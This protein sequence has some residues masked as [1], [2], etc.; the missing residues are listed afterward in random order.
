MKSDAAG[1]MDPA[2]HGKM[3]PDASFV[4]KAAMGG[5]MEVKLGEAATTR[6]SEEAVK[7]YGRRMVD[8]HGKANGELKDLATKK[9]WSLPA[10]LDE[11]HKKMSEKMTMLSGAEFDRAYSEHMLKDHEMVVKEFE[12]AAQKAAD[13]DLRAWATKTLP[14]LKEHLQMARELPANRKGDRSMNRVTTGM[15]KKTGNAGPGH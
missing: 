15:E 13:A 3:A 8:D 5:M 1:K 4:N 6:A 7:V 11:M 12:H 10:D 9:G 2:M 14:T